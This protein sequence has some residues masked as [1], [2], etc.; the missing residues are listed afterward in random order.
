MTTYARPNGVDATAVG[1][2]AQGLQD[3]A[4]PDGTRFAASVHWQGGFRNEIRV[5]DLRPTYADEP[6][7]LGGTDTAA[8]PVELILGALGSC[9]RSGTPPARSRVA[10]RSRTCGSTSPG[11]STCPSSSA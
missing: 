11:T 10:S 2:F 8:N 7:V 3:A 9:P 5:R 6:E 1:A 4:P